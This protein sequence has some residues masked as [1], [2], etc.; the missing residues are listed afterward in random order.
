ML[1]TPTQ[2]MDVGLSWAAKLFER[3]VWAA[4]TQRELRGLVDVITLVGSLRPA[5]QPYFAGAEAVAGMRGPQQPPLF[6]PSRGSSRNSG[7][8]PADLIPAASS[9]NC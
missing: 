7:N 6:A 3:L 4:S 2:R 5:N 8:D 1:A 9:Q